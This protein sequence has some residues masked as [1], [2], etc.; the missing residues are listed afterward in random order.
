MKILITA[1]P[2]HE[3]I[4]PV[5][6]IGNRSSGRM[7]AALAAAAVEAGHGVTAVLGPVAIG[8]PAGVRRIDVETAAQMRDAVLA[9]FPQCDLLIMAAAVA[10]FRPKRFSEEKLARSGGLTIECEPTED[11]LGLV[12]GMKRADQRTVGFSLE[13]NGGL[14]RAREKLARKGLDMIVY[15]PAE[16]MNSPEI[17]G[18]LIYPDGRVEAMARQ[19]KDTFAAALIA[20]AAALLS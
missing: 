14:A 4:D 20:R 13:S 2:T 19:A 3:P 15:N 18:T 16:T 1:G 7:G 9:E 6:Y 10:D 17:E 12:A 5:R 11:I 8:L